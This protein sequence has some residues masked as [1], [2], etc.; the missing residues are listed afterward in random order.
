MAEPS[1]Q[2]DSAP[3]DR[4]DG[5]TIFA[6]RFQKTYQMAKARFYAQTNDAEAAWKFGQACFDWADCVTSN[7]GREEVALQGIN[8]CRTLLNRDTNSVPGHY[9]LGMNL[10]QL[11][12]TKSLGALKIVQEMEIEF[13]IALRL[14]PLFDLGGPDRNLGLLYHQA[15]GWPI[16][17]G[18]RAKAK[19]HLQKA[20]KLSPDYPENV[21]NLIEADLDWGDRSGALRELKVLDALWPTARLKFTGEQWESSWA[22]WT[23]RREQAKKKAAASSRP[24]ESP[25]KLSGG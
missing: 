2:I 6:S 7:A 13:K 3:F 14:D 17:L 1:L 23:T 10:G 5:Q 21:L 11:A 20:L 4:L 22:D 19:Q 16:S 8:A 9:Y 18:S 25:H 24:V 15:P 12:S